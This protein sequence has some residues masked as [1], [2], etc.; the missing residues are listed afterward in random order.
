M[1]PVL[2]NL[3]GPTLLTLASALLGVIIML[4]LVYLIRRSWLRPKV[5]D[6]VVWAVVWAIGGA[7][8]GRAD[9]DIEQITAI[10]LGAVWGALIAVVQLSGWSLRHK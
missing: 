2:F 10:A 1:S 5:V 6:V 9:D 8:V 4:A 3:D 7:I